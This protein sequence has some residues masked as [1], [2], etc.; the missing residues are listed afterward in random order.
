MP[1]SPDLKP[2]ETGD[3]INYILSLSSPESAKKVEHL[4]SR[5]VA[6]KLS[7]PLGETIAD[8][9]WNGPST[10]IV[11]S[12]LWWRDG[13]DPGLQVQAVHD[14]RTMAIRLTW[15]D[16]TR[17]EAA[18]RPQDFTDMAAVELY[19]G[20]RTREPFLGMG[21]AD[22]AVDLWLWN[23]AAQADRAAYNDVDSTY[24]HMSIDMYPLEKGDPAA[25]GHATARQSKEFLTAWAAGNLRSDPTRVLPG[26]HLQARGFGSTTLRPGT[27]QLVA[28]EGG[29]RDNTWT[30]VLRRPLAVE[31]DAGIPLEPGA[32]R[33]IA[34]AVWDGAARD[35]NG[36]KLVSIWHDLELE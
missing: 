8:S 3:M 35:R 10:P 21:A 26:T 17:N 29:W 19:Q 25:Q 34:F 4:R 31:S 5:I 7:A 14:G 22:G 28:A 20:D 13:T 15:K 27:S 24:P 1:A 12:P 2:A 23:A 32:R 6:R 30:V 11:I 36:Q 16:G 18:I 9:V 33:S